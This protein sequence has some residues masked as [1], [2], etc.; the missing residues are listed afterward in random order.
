M[1]KLGGIER[2]MFYGGKGQTILETAGVYSTPA[3]NVKVS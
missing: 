3:K 1:M 2:C